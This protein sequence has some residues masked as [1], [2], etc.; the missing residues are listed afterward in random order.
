M[1]NGGEF[2]ARIIRELKLI[3]KDMVI[4][5]GKPRHPQSQGSIER[6]NADVKNMLCM[7]MKDNYSKNW[8]LGLKFV[9][10]QKNNSFHRTIKCT[11][12]YATFG[13]EMNY[14]IGSSAVPKD[15]LSSLSTEE[16]LEKVIFE[17]IQVLQEIQEIENLLINPSKSSNSSSS[18][19]SSVAPCCSKSLENEF[20][21]LEMEDEECKDCEDD[22]EESDELSEQEIDEFVLDLIDSN[23]FNKV[24]GE[25]ISVAIDFISKELIGRTKNKCGQKRKEPEQCME[26][27]DLVMEISSKVKCFESNA[28]KLKDIQNSSVESLRN[29]AE[30]M[31]QQHIHKLGEAK[32]GDT[33]QVSVPDVDR[34]PADPV[35]ILA[36]IL[37][38]NEHGL[39][40][41]A[42]KHGI[43][44]GWHARNYFQICK[45]KL[46]KFE[47][48]N[49]TKE[50][51]LRELN[52]LHSISGG[53][54]FL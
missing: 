20:N 9:Q 12:Y 19:S 52:G 1:D 48:L 11:P 36:Y 2:V 4:V 24:F 53:Q 10:M 44:S 13:M 50:S 3:W 28:I 25:I 45:Q 42:T 16:E 34:G 32:V 21:Q 6:A 49:L 51:S 27:D 29:A 41:L 23:I 33:V 30:V 5:H 46:I 14:G 18:S 31:A 43:I 38:I 7:W 22:E 17:S 15:L 35:N 39:Y 8:S 47:S 40:R 37:K 26:S 54:G